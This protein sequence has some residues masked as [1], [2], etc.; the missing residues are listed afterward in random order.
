M[1][2]LALSLLAFLAIAGAQAQP[3]GPAT[4]S[5]NQ[6]FQVSQA[7]TALTRIATGGTQSISLC[8]IAFNSGAAASTAQLRRGTGT[9]CATGT[10]DVTPAISL[11]INGVYVDHRSFAYQS[12]AV[13]QDLCLVTTGVGPAQVTVYYTIQ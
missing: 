6:V 8:G 13:G 12:L 9:N 10:A 3:V 11:G 5:C 7:A 2:K 4:L 1:K